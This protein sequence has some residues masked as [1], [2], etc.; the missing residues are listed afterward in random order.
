MPLTHKSDPEIGTEIS[1]NRKANRITE[2][3]RAWPTQSELA[4]YARSGLLAHAL[5]WVRD[6]TVANGGASVPQA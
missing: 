5:Q 3:N 6:D 2:N 4:V 1:R